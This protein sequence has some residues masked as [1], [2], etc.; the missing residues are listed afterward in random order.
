MILFNIY[1]ETSIDQPYNVDN[2][3][4]IKSFSIADTDSANYLYCSGNYI[5]SSATNYLA[6]L[7]VWNTF[8]GV[9]ILN[10]DYSETFTY[11]SINY[12]SSNLVTS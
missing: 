8:S 7:T 11:Y 6:G 1:E 12:H 3:T 9:A 10:N 5:D 4:L 2:V